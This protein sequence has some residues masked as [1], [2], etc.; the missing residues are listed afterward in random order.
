MKRSTS[1][2]EP[3]IG[4]SDQP[5]SDSYIPRSGAR[6][7]KCDNVRIYG[8]DAGYEKEKDF[9]NEEDEIGY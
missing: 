1:D 2:V 5:R 4:L 9:R 7:K 3:K 8:N 6:Y